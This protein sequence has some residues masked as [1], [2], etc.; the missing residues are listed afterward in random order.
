VFSSFWQ[1]PRWINYCGK[2][3]IQTLP[4]NA[5][6]SSND[7]RCQASSNL[8]HSLR[9]I[10]WD[11]TSWVFL[12]DGRKVFLILVYQVLLALVVLHHIPGR[13]PRE[14]GR[15][16]DEWPHPHNWCR[17]SS[18]SC[19][20]QTYLLENKVVKLW[21]ENP[22]HMTSTV[23]VG[24]SNRVIS[25]TKNYPPALHRDSCWAKLRR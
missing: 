15:E 21:Q 6:S 9:Q 25:L 19:Y 10:V 16:G 18:C 8:W 22:P 3:C 13:F 20:V 7:S 2:H 4:V 1:K 5:I 24:I 11:V 12:E 14:R 17:R 23:S